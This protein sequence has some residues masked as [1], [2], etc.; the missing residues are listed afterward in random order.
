MKMQDYVKMI[1]KPAYIKKYAESCR[2][3][4][5]IRLSEDLIKV[6][7]KSFLPLETSDQIKLE[8][9]KEMILP[10]P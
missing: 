3:Y 6:L 2:D 1:T 5:D 4:H 9:P 7:N 10:L 8:C